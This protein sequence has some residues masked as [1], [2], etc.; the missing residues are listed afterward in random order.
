MAHGL[1]YLFAAFFIT[2]IILGAYI[3]ALHRQIQALR[4]E[5]EMLRAQRRQLSDAPTAGELSKQLTELP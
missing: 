3:L 5:V 4:A 2:W 1:V